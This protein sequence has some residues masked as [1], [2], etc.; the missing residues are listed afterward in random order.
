MPKDS[1]KEQLKI[2]L[3][4]FFPAVVVILLLALGIFF[5]QAQVSIVELNT[6]AKSN[7]RLAAE[8]FREELGD[9]I[10]DLR[11]LSKDK[12]LED[13]LEMKVPEARISLSN[14][15]LV[16]ALE[17]KVFDQIRILDIDGRE[18]VRVNYNDGAPIS[19]SKAQ[20]QDKSGRYYF[21]KAVAKGQGQHFISQFDLNMEKGAIEQPYK[22]TLRVSAPVFSPSG[23][24]IGVLV[25]NYRG[26]YLLKTIREMIPATSS[27]FP[28]LLDQNGHYLIGPTEEA[29]W[30][31][32]FGKEAA[33]PTDFSKVFKY[34]ASASNGQI[35]SDQYLFTFRNVT[36]GDNYLTIVSQINLASVYS[37]IF[38]SHIENIVIIVLLILVSALASW[39]VA[40]SRLARKGWNI[41]KN[42]LADFRETA[43]DWLWETDSQLRFTDISLRMKDITGIN[44]NDYIG[45]QFHELMLPDPDQPG[46]D[47]LLE[48]IETRRPIK[49]VPC[50][51]ENFL[52]QAL[53]FNVTA[54]P[55]FT[56][57]VFS[58]YRGTSQDVTNYRRLSRELQDRVVAAEFAERDADNYAQKLAEAQRISHTGNWSHDLITGK[59]YWSEEV[60]RIFGVDPEAFDLEYELYLGLV[61]PDDRDYVVEQHENSKKNGVLH[62]FEYRIVRKS[63]DDDVRWVQERC[64][65]HCSNSGEIIR[66]E[67]TVQDITERKAAEQTLAEAKE[68]AESA[69]CSKSD[70]L[71]NM[72]HEI[73]TPMNGIIGMTHLALQT[74]LDDKQKN[75]IGKAH[76][77]AENLLGILNDILDFSKIEAG[78]LNFEE[79]DFNL[80]DVI[81][82]FVNL[83]RFKAEEKSIR[84]L[85]RIGRDVPMALN[86]DPLRLSQVL[87][88]LGSNAVK[89][90]DAGD[91]VSL[92]VALKE[93]SG[94]EVVLQ[95]AIKDTGIGMSQEQLEG[96]FQPFGQADSSTTRKYGGTGLGLIISKKIVQLMN[97][98]IAVESE[99]DAGSTFRFTVRLKTQQSESSQN[100]ALGNQTEMDV[101]QAIVSM[102]GA[103]ILLVEDNE[104]N[105][106]I[107]LDILTMS[108]MRVEMAFDGQEALEFLA[109]EDFD[110]V[111]MD[112][113]MPVMDGYEATRQIRE[114][115]KFK[116]LPIIALTANA[117]KG[118]REKVLAVG[119][120]D[121][122]SKPVNPD[123]MFITLAKWINARQ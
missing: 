91:S 12:D 121:H 1:T 4:L 13:A 81:D 115:K 23:S 17:K 89:F 67:G 83:L 32:M 107:V 9:V 44:P 123:L 26:H 71:A 31:F 104:I 6:S 122:I 94:H 20:L 33:F 78:K 57:G 101:D 88:N 16:F 61:H 47:T 62:I 105:R 96:L 87:I 73:R 72:S 63:F 68:V 65:Y 108:G 22:P 119:M 97:G 49:K 69:N 55:Y 74:E 42:K 120:N 10:S 84:L 112:C 27:G 95:F 80:K 11:I 117:M 93:E 40:G 86:G 21:K 50:K 48:K 52:G 30:G 2:A 8:F 14:K 64:G 46:I 66:S 45:K 98:E 29:E 25:M 110:G 53:Q 90:G 15:L 37:A 43:S 36:V 35:E 70:F 100:R 106:E 28:L 38:K 60:F 109:K 59:L 3:K 99:Q 118:D 5:S 76:R 111:L 103:K 102:R 7:V 79:V 18:V 24:K 54:K 77:S 19:V 75:Y 92:N 34:V 113:Q 51:I 39:G 114:Q 82:N 56:D 85:V 116:D 58:G 41:T